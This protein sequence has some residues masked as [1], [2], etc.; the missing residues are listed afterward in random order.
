M[1]QLDM[2][3]VLELLQQVPDTVMYLVHRTG[4]TSFL[5]REDGSDIK[6][7][8]TIGARPCCSWWVHLNGR[9]TGSSAADTCQTLWLRL[10]VNIA[11]HTTCATQLDVLAIA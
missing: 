11:P 1:W 3:E 9:Q 8:V 7:K 6:R 2:Q 5:V 4:P 10:C